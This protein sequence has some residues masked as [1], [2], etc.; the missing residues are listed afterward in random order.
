[1]INLVILVKPQ[2][3]IKSSQLRIKIQAK[4]LIENKQVKLD[5]NLNKLLMREAAIRIENLQLM[6][7]NA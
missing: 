1:M 7:D 5:H 4:I 2:N 6:L 3:Q